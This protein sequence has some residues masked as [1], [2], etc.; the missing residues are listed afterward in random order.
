MH[1][2]HLIMTT[3]HTHK[4]HIM[5]ASTTVTAHPI[6]TLVHPLDTPIMMIVPL[7]MI[8]KS[9]GVVIVYLS[10]SLIGSVL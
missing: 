4:H 9:S 3:Q 8:R 10:V 6:D 5:S 2:G 7:T 1:Q